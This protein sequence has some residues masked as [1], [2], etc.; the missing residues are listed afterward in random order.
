MSVMKRCWA[1]ACFYQEWP[2]EARCFLSKNWK[3]KCYT[4]VLHK[5]SSPSLQCKHKDSSH[6]RCEGCWFWLTARRSPSPNDEG[7]CFLSIYSF[8][9]PLWNYKYYYFCLRNLYSLWF[10]TFIQMEFK[11]L[12]YRR[13]FSRVFFF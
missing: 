5:K 12:K 1:S 8:N 11:I 3:H 9:N 6:L 7:L 4:S 2:D 13:Y 10:K